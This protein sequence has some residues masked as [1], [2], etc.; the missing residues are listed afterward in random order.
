VLLV[1]AVATVEVR[2]PSVRAL[3]LGIVILTLLATRPKPGVLLRRWV[4]TLGAVIA[5]IVPWL[6]SGNFARALE[7]GGR[8]GAATLIALAFASTLSLGELPSALRAL[9]LPTDFAST[10]HTMLWQVGNIGAEG[11]RLVLARRLRGARGA[12][13]PEILA[14]LLVRTTAR[15]ERVD[16][17]MRLRGAHSA[18]AASRA[19][20]GVADLVGAAIAASI[21]VGLHVWA[22]SVT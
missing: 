7:V 22:K 14:E 2:A 21:G 12:V 9:G 11:R 20:L 16:L 13:G 4:W 19:G 5:L 17:A 18:T 1:A 15:A 8:A 6:W 3:V 10:V